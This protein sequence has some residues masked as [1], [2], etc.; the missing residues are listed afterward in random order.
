M[1]PRAWVAGAVSLMLLAACSSYKKEPDF[2]SDLARDSLFGPAP[3][4]SGW[5]PRPERHTQRFKWKMQM[6][7][8]TLKAQFDASGGAPGEGGGPATILM[9]TIVPVENLYRATPFGRLLTEQI[10]TEMNRHGFGVVE[11]RKTDVYLIRDHEGEFSLSRDVDWLGKEYRS[12]A[13]LVGV[14]SISG[15]QALINARLVDTRDSRILAAASVMMNLQGD[16]FLTQIV[17]MAAAD[18]SSS[19]GKAAAAAQDDSMGSANVRKR[20][21]P[22]VDSG[23]E[24]LDAGIAALAAEVAEQARERLGK[25]ARVA[26]ATFVDVNNFQRA[27][28]FGRFLTE[29][30]IGELADRGYTALEAR[31]APDLYIDLFVGELGLT[32]DMSQL[33]ASRRADAMLVGTY[34]RAGDKVAVSARMALA[35]TQ[36]VA[37]AA[38]IVVEAGKANPFVTAMLDREITAVPVTE[39]VEGF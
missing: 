18:D 14:Y 32:R 15:G 39:T 12:D 3:A 19:A 8:Q 28:A 23:A 30:L 25:N 16:A 11:A 27:N 33:M 31:L 26:V 2:V 6:L 21:L 22:G 38:E 4:M 24:I 20:V 29:R 34:A 10:I 7:A 13:V 35:G 36:E 9:T 17:S 5:Y 37:G 1:K